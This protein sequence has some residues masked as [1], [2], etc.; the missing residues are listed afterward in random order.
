[1]QYA[2]QKEHY[3]TYYP[4]A[5]YQVICLDEKPV[6]RLYLA[7]LPAEFRILDMAILPENRNAGIA[8]V[9]IKNLLSDS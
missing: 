5:E 9:V 4:E 1:M 2:A 6:G 7:R 8:T 3:R